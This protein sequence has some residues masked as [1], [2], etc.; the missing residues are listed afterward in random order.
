MTNVIVFGANGL[1]GS[2][3]VKEALARGHRVTVID[4]P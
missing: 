1:S 2:H 3:V 4:Q